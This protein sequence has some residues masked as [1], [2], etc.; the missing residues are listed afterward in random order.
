M[1]P[2]E[3]G[4]KAIGSQGYCGGSGIVVVEM[5]VVCHKKIDVFFQR[6]KEEEEEAEVEAKVEEEEEVEVEVEVEGHYFP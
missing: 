2:F 1:T 6:E 3:E 4:R 5:V